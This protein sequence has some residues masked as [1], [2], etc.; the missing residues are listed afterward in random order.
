[1][2]RFLDWIG[3]GK[4]GRK[5]EMSGEVAKCSLPVISISH[6]FLSGEKEKERRN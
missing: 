1:M 4:G 6:Q 3:F 5:G 2:E